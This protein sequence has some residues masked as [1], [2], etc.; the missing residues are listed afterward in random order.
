MKIRTNISNI[1]CHR[2][3]H[4]RT[5]NCRYT[6]N[7]GTSSTQPPTPTKVSTTYVPT[8]SDR[9]RDAVNRAMP[10]AKDARTSFKLF[11]VWQEAVMSVLI[12]TGLDQIITHPSYPHTICT[13]LIYAIRLI[14]HALDDNVRMQYVTRK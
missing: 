13:E 10:S 4:H 8:K 11:N 7:I 9:L 2:S 6:I 1:R 12:M 14:K 5:E 3:C